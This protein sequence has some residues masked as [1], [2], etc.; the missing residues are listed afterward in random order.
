MVRIVTGKRIGKTGVIRPS[1]AGSVFNGS[2][3]EILLTRRKDIGVWCLPGGGMDAGESASEGCVR[4][5]FE[6]TGLMVKVTHLIGVYS[7]PHMLVEYPGGDRVHSMA[8]NFLAEPIGGTLGIS[9]ETIDV[10]YFTLAEMK[11]MN[12]W[13]HQ[14][15]LIIDAFS[16]SEAAFI[17]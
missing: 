17:R 7:S 5:V 11:S 6:E 9:D 15:Q 14:M 4:E 3:E 12:I 2:G 1:T 8:L 16:K 10:G 13:E